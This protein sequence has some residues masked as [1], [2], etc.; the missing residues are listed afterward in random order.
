MHHFLK[1]QTRAAHTNLDPHPLL[2]QL[3]SQCVSVIDY[4]CV[5]QI[6]LSWYEPLEKNLLQQHPN[7]FDEFGVK[8]KTPLLKADLAELGQHQSIPAALDSAY[9]L[10]LNNAQL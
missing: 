3:M 2:L 4:Q 9:R 10:S 5:L 6:F 7:I 1:T 8:L